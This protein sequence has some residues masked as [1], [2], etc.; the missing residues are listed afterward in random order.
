MHKNKKVQ[1]T[2]KK[3]KLTETAEE[4]AYISGLLNEDFKSTSLNMFQV[5][6][7]TKD[8]EQKGTRTMKSFQIEILEL[9]IK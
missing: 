5:L 4:E 1:P 2:Q 6:K 3:K 8:K 9:K 7:K